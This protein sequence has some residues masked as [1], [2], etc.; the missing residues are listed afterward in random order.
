MADIDL[1]IPDQDPG[2][3]SDQQVMAILNTLGIASNWDRDSNGPAG[4]TGPKFIY[5]TLNDDI[6]TTVDNTIAPLNT[7]VDNHIGGL[8]NKH[9]TDH[10][11]L[12]T[13][14]TGST[15][16]TFYSADSSISDALDTISSA[17]KT[18][19]DAIGD[20][21]SSATIIYRLDAIEGYT[22]T[23]IP[24]G[25]NL[26]VNGADTTTN[27]LEEGTTNLYSPFIHNEAN[28]FI[29]LDTT[30]FSSINIGGA[31]LTSG[32]ALD[33]GNSTNSIRLPIGTDNQRPVTPQPGMIRYNSDLKVYELYDEVSAAWQPFGKEVFIGFYFNETN[34][35]VY[36]LGIGDEEFAIEDYIEWMTVTGAE[37]IIEN[38]NL[39]IR[40]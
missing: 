13:F 19:T 21:T 32:I 39:K 34:D 30:R 17:I 5:D 16:S 12:I 25:N 11:E 4:H 36:D 29:Y 18:N 33:V 3:P 6:T 10:I 1:N 2:G 9:T 35:L 14:V 20:S 24:E 22:T 37:F 8:D 31:S 28:S 15:S 40:M 7:K 26:Y 38:N 27:D 23:D